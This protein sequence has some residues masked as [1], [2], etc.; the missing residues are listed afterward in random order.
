MFI[1]KLNMGLP[2]QARVEKTATGVE[3]HWL[4]GKEKNS[5][6]SDQ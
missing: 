4:F 6:R 3:T 2:L 1:N 5:G